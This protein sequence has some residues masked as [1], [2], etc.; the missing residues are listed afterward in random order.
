M[1]AH[2]DPIPPTPGPGALKPD[3]HHL[4]GGP[5]R[6]PITEERTRELAAFVRKFGLDPSKVNWNRLNRAFIHRSYRA[7]SDIDEDNER[8]EFLGD[9]VVGLV[10]TEYLLRERPGSD[11]GVLSKLRATLVSR[12]ALGQI[13]INLGV[14][15]LM[16]LGAGEERTGGRERSS[17]LGSA[18]EAICGAFYLDFAWEEISIPIQQSIILPALDLAENSMVLDYKSQLQEWS[19]KEFQRVP[20]YRVVGEGGP[21]HSKEFEV[22]VHLDGKVLGRGRGKRKKQAENDAARVA[23][24]GIGES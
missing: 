14:G 13:A 9:S 12:A 11:E 21:D 16:L 8:L 23:L 7:E 2:A 3:E 17:I 15:R 6:C 10:C 18:L 4:G 5:R 1:S 19:Q 24:G 20:I 22:E